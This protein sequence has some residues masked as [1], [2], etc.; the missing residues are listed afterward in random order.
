MPMDDDGG[1]W[2]QGLHSWVACC[3][4]SFVCCR[5]GVSVYLRPHRALCT[6]ALAITLLCLSPRSQPLLTAAAG[7]TPPWRY[8][9]SPYGTCRASMLQPTPCRFDGAFEGTAP[10][11]G[12]WVWYDTPTGRGTL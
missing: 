7:R 8:V 11:S 2:S 4:L 1:G 6:L 5:R 9:W 12:W 10:V 3:P